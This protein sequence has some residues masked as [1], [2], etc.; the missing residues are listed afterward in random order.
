MY[1]L[2]WPR[3]QHAGWIIGDNLYILGGVLYVANDNE[4]PESQV[5]F[6]P[7]SSLFLIVC[8]F[9]II[10]FFL[11]SLSHF[12]SHPTFFLIFPSRRRNISMICGNFLLRT[13]LG[14]DVK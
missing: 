4:A 11:L 6:S 5:S 12:V 1:T 10:F 14:N 2:P 7:F 8:H 3:T 9:V 13:K